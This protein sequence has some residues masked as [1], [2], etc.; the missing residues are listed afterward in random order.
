MEPVK[1]AEQMVEFQKAIFDNNFS[2]M[3]MVQEQGESM[4]KMSLEQ[5][6]WLPENG[7]KVV[8]EWLM[9]YK[10]GRE[11][12]KRIVDGNF[13]RIEALFNEKE[14]KPTKGDAKSGEKKI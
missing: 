8:N 9:G 6:A 10:Q 7:K 14:K 5:A 2:T 4:I 13:K 1:I 3:G 11:D 12:F